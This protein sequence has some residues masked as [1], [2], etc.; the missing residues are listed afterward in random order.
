MHR[1][2]RMSVPRQRMS[3][4]CLVGLLPLLL[5]LPAQAI[6]Y[7][8]PGNVPADVSCAGLV[9][10]TISVFGADTITLASGVHITGSVTTAEGQMT[11]ADGVWI[12]GSL[13]TDSGTILVGNRVKIGGSITAAKTGTIDI[14]SAAEVLGGI[15]TDIGNITV[16]DQAIVATLTTAGVTAT[17]GNIHFGIQ[18]QVG[19]P[20]IV[21]GGVTAT[22]G[23]IHFGDQGH[24]YGGV[25][26]TK[27]DVFFGPTSWI[28]GAITATAGHVSFGDF[29]RMCGAITATAGNVDVGTSAWIGAAITATKGYVVVKNLS[30]VVGA[31]ST[32]D[33]PMLLGNDVQVVGALT[34]TTGDITYGDRLGH[35]AAI[36][37]GGTIYAGKDA[38][39]GVTVLAACT[40]APPYASASTIASA[41][42]CLEA[43]VA[44]SNINSVP[45]ARNPLYTKL[46]GTPFAFDVLALKTDGTQETA[47]VAGSSAKSVKLEWVDG[48]GTTACADRTSIAAAVSQVLGFSAS[49][50]GRKTAAVMAVDNAYSNLRCRVTDANQTP[51]VV[52]CS[53]DNFAVRPVALVVSQNTPTLNAGS[54]FTL[55][56]TAVKTDLTPA[57]NYRGVPTLNLA[58]ITGAPGFTLAALAPQTLPAAVNGTS[59]SSFTYDE[60]GSFTLPVSSSGT[61]GISD[62]SFT[63]VDASGD[64]IANSA[65]NTLDS[66]GKYG[67]LIAQ[68]NALSV[69]RFYPDHFDIVSAFAPACVGGG[70]SYMDQAFVLGYSVT[71][72]SLSRSLPK[73]SGNTALTLYSGG[74]LRFAAL[75]ADTDWVSRLSPALSSPFAPTW[76]NG[77]Y[78]PS[79]ASM[80]FSRPTSTPDATWG[81]FDALNMGLAVDDADG[82]AYASGVLTFDSPTP[83]ACLNT[84]SSACRKYA[85]LTGGTTHMRLGRLKL[86]NTYGSERLPL[87]MPLAFEYWAAS[88]WAK[89]NLDN[90]SIVA[91]SNFSFVFPEGTTAKPNNLLPCNSALTITGSAPAFALSLSVPGK[92]GWADLTLNLGLTAMGTQCTAVQSPGLPGQQAATTANMPWLQYNASNPIARATFGIFKSPLVYRR[93][94]Y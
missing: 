34:S 73:P 13:N 58:Q 61:Y 72:K 43:G 83:T 1:L 82:V 69:G 23:S 66:S 32:V 60:V 57:T 26:A 80:V 92:A 46:A 39:T 7:S 70:F 15:T 94:N 12:D 86:S 56:A 16:G 81:P 91:S 89:N 75:N 47:F 53:S 36:V 77:S 29:G 51:A 27:G 18:A 55:Q 22:T 33:F 45:S 87:A 2:L 25:T 5:G 84:A 24:V 3:R 67:C 4:P 30:Q 19:A 85:S 64:C 17:N 35:A 28:Y 37:T 41:F 49:D 68:S 14:G 62:S 90:C 52:S 42:A 78:T 21:S 38:Y 74:Q 10:T 63:Q 44:Y 76:I 71:A 11:L 93:E 54:T 48:S 6:D 20:G 31:I 79:S 50:A 65:S 88:G 40:A 9:C 59:S 8:I